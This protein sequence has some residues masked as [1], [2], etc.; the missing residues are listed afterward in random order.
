MPDRPTRATI[1]NLCREFGVTI[2]AKSTYPGPRQTRAVETIGRI[3]RKRGIG[4][5]RLVLTTLVETENNQAC[6][7]EVSLWSI[8]DMLIICHS[9]VETRF[10]DW[11]DAFDHIPV[12]A[13]Q[14]L[15]QELS[16]T[17]SQRYALDG[18]LYERLARV[19]GPNAM[20]PDLLD[21]RR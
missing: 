20:Q 21:E 17:V 18:M 10:A 5:M 9:V 3:I 14:A 15:C 6:L 1:A 7:D 2:I 8:S 16:G 12:G 4:H 13:L 19:F 11:L